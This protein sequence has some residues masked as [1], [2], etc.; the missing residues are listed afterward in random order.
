MSW[1]IR[2]A[3]TLQLRLQ[4]GYSRPEGVDVA[5]LGP[6]RQPVGVD[7]AVGIVLGARRA[8]GRSSGSLRLSA[9]ALEA[10]IPAPLT[11]EAWTL[12]SF[13]LGPCERR[14]DALLLLLLLLL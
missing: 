4:L 7:L 6:S 5:L 2:Q 11:G 9:V 8:L 13:G 10:A 3:L 14:H 1:G 12:P